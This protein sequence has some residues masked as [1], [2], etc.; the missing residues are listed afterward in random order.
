M[1]ISCAVVL[2]G[3]L[4]KL[5]FWNGSET[6]LRV[7]MLLLTF[8]VLAWAVNQRV[9]RRALVVAVVG[10]LMLS[11]SSENLMRQLYR[12]DPQLVKIIVYQIHHPHDRAASEACAKQMREYRH[13]H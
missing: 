8:F 10:G 11:I 3:C 5:M 12:D 2:I 4:F 7:G 6:M 9:N 13:N 1:Y